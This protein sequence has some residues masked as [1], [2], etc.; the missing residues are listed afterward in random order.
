MTSGRG[1]VVANGTG[2]H[3]GNL[4]RGAGGHDAVLDAALGDEFADAPGAPH[5]IDGLEV[6]VMPV[7]QQVFGVDILPQRR[8][9]E[10]RLQVVGSQSV[11]RKKRVGVAVT[12]DAGHGA[13]RVVIK[14]RRRAQHPQDMPVFPVV[15]QNVVQQVVVHGIGRFAGA[16]RAECERL[17]RG[18]G[19]LPLEGEAIYIDATGAVLL[20]AHDHGVPRAQQAGLHGVR[21]PRTQHH[22]AVHA[23]GL[24]ELPP[25]VDFEV[26]GEDRCG[27][28]AVGQLPVLWCEPDGNVR[29]RGNNRL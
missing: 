24:Y 14:G 10:R 19:I 27:V 16:P 12:D 20:P 21:L 8:V 23:R 11:A 7:R 17:R 5:Q 26:F 6:V 2:Q 4:P 13:A 29:R 9:K 28:E 3:K 18:G 22:R 15:A 1:A 25:P